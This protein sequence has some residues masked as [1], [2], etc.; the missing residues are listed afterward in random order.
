MSDVAADA[1]A[2]RGAFAV[3]VAG[4]SL[5]GLLKGLKKRED[6]D[7]KKW[8]IFTVDERVV[9]HKR[10]H[11]CANSILYFEIMASTGRVDQQQRI[12]YNS[13]LSRAS[14]VNKS[15]FNEFVCRITRRGLC[16][17]VPGGIADAP[18]PAR[19]SHPDSNIGALRAA[20]LKDVPVPDE[21]ARLHDPALH[22]CRTLVWHHAEPGCPPSPFPTNPA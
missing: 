20:L 1:V 16:P 3:A 22:M 14:R 6:V 17:S 4:G 9:A 19:C 11:A 15:G 21:Q 8:Y 13:H 2:E 12:R 18:A 10:V 7:W 5:V